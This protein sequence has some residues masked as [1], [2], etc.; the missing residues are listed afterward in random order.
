M[1]KFDHFCI[2]IGNTVGKKNYLWFLCFVG[3][4]STGA[5][6]FVCTSL[7]QV[8][9]LWLGFTL[10]LPLPCPFTLPLPLPLPL[11]PTPT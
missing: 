10:P 5:I 8:L 1:L 11:T 4:T 7:W 6:Y 2:F 3:L 9:H